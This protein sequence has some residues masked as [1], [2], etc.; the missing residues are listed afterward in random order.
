[1]QQWLKIACGIKVTGF[2]PKND[3]GQKGLTRGDMLAQAFVFVREQGKP[4]GHADREQY[5]QQRGKYALDATVVEVAEAE[6]A[7][8]DAAENDARNQKTGND[9]EKIDADE[10]AGQP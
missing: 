7:A 4:A 5:E 10:A 3:V 9:E 2:L 8:V 6:R 1:M